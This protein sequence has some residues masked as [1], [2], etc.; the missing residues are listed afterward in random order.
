MGKIQ[1]W[2]QKGLTLE[3]VISD[4]GFLGRIEVFWK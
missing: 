4:G 3:D 2:L 1:Q